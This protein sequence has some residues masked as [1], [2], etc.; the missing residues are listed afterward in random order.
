MEDLFGWLII[1]FPTLPHENWLLSMRLTSRP[2][3]SVSQGHYYVFAE[4]GRE[5][6]MNSGTEQR[7]SVLAPKQQLETISDPSV[8]CEGLGGRRAEAEG[9]LE[10]EMRKPWELGIS[11]GICPFPVMGKKIFCSWWNLNSPK[12]APKQDV[13]WRVSLAFFS[14]VKLNL[15]SWERE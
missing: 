5:L 14:E 3:G 7:H 1:N 12:A 11:Q 4:P 8:T 15:S 6:S 2:T 9:T 10:Q 13:S